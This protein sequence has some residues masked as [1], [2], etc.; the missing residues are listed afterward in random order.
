MCSRAVPLPVA[1]TKPLLAGLYSAGWPPPSRSHTGPMAT[2]SA[3]TM[4]MPVPAW[5]RPV[6]GAA[7]S[8]SCEPGGSAAGE[9]V[10]G[11]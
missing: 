7:H 8:A 2:S 1:H 11:A 5:L 6:Y 10:G 9:A 4:A 3:S